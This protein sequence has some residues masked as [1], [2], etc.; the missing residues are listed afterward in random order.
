MLQLGVFETCFA[1]ARTSRIG[2]DDGVSAP[3]LRSTV[4]ITR[5]P[6]G[7]FRVTVALR[8]GTRRRGAPAG[9]RPRLRTSCPSRAAAGQPSGPP[10]RTVQ[11]PARRPPRQRDVTRAGVFQHPHAARS[12]TSEWCSVA[13][14][15]PSPTAAAV[16]ATASV[17]AT[18]VAIERRGRNWMTLCGS[19]R[20]AAR[21]RSRRARRG[22]R[23]VRCEG[24]RRGSAAQAHEL[25]LAVLAPGKMLLVAVA[26]LA[27]RAS[28]A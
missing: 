10:R 12:P 16:A 17:A 1:T 14:Q 5:A 21:I 7:T 22:R 4:T 19:S 18:D 15:M 24:E 20:A 3:P 23:P 13:A 28:R 25:G 11:R 27:L 8:C 26:I 6:R 9:S 2:V